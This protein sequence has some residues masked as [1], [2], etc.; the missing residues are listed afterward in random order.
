MTKD[1]VA[2]EIF[3][4]ND[5][6]AHK[7]IMNKKAAYI[8]IYKLKIVTRHEKTGLMYTKYIHS[9]YSAYLLY[10]L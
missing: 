9:Y 3:H 7:Y 8:Y 4:H 2:N 1:D 10:R 6:H 5:T